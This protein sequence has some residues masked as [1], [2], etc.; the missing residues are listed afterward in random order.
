MITRG[1]PV[2]LDRRV[3]QQA[4]ALKGEG[5]S[6]AIVC[7]TGSDP[8][9]SATEL[10]GIRIFRYP[11]LHEAATPVGRTIR[12]L[13]LLAWEFLITCRAFFTIGVDVLHTC[14]PP[15]NI[16]LV[17]AF[18]KYFYGKKLVFDYRAATEDVRNEGL[19][20]RTA[21]LCIVANDALSQQAA[22]LGNMPRE[23]AVVIR[24]VPDLGCIRLT[25]P[26]PSLKAERKYLVCW[27]GVLDTKEKVQQLI[28]AARVITQDM[29]RKDIHFILTGGGRVLQKVKKLAAL[30]GVTEYVTFTGNVSGEETLQAISTSDVCVEPAPLHSD[31]QECRIMEYMALARPIVQ[32]E[33]AEG[34]A[35]AG[36]ASLYA[37]PEDASD[38]ADKIAA[39]L[40]DPNKRRELGD[41]GRARVEGELSWARE[42][43]RLLAAY[44]T[45]F[46]VRKKR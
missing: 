28:A 20:C 26:V 1:V 40:G 31:A 22:K 34:R 10:E 3:W 27:A 8:E 5:Y 33:S 32:F 23:R 12:I 18:F 29:K 42:A 9:T 21:N 30:E 43:P 39:L 19:A 38:L 14:N 41:A 44:E 17:G 7:P 25:P 16:F 37:N 2:P 15:S 6:V 4:V 46:I 24:S 35:L 11:Y 13:A 45:M 36:E